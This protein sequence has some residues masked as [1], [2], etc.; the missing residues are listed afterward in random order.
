MDDIHFDG[1]IVDFEYIL[2][3]CSR[4]MSDHPETAEWYETLGDSQKLWIICCYVHLNVE[5]SATRITLFEVVE[6]CR[7]AITVAEAVADH[8]NGQEEHK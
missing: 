6:N 8:V 7:L 2:R 5:R 4:L 3:T 1:S